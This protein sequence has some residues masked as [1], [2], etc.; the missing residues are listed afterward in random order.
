MAIGVGDDGGQSRWVGVISRPDVL[1]AISAREGGIHELWGSLSDAAS[2]SDAGDA[3]EL[4]ETLAQVAS[5]HLRPDDWNMPYGPALSLDG[6]RTAI[7]AD[8]STGGLE[9]LRAVAPA[10]PDPLFRSRVLDVVALLSTHRDR[11]ELE[12]A[13]VDALLEVPIRPE[14]WNSDSDAWDRALLVARRYRRPARARLARLEQTLRRCIRTSEVGY[15]PLHVADL[16]RKHRL[17]RDRAT[18]IAARLKRLATRAGDDTERERA[19]LEGAAAWFAWGNDR[20]SSYRETLAVVHSLIAEGERIAAQGG[21]RTAMRAAHLFEHALQKVRSLPRATR[22]ELGAS[23]LTSQLARRIRELGAASL[24][25]MHSFDS[26]PI[27]LSSAARDAIDR[28]KG[29]SVDE[30]LI[31]FAALAEFASFSREFVQAEERL[32]AHP[33]QSLLSYVHYSA[34]GRVIY[35]SSGRGGTPIYGVDPAVWRQIIESYSLRVRLLT[36]GALWPA[37]VQISNEHRLNLADFGR[38]VSMSGIVPDDRIGQFARGLYY[39]WNADFSTGMQLLVPQIEHLVRFHLAD[40]GELTST[41]T[42]EQTEMEIGI[43]GLME[44]AAADEVFGVDLAFELRALFCG[45]LGPN[46]RNEVAHGLLDDA[47]STSADA[48]YCWWFALRLVFIPYWN[49]AHD[50]VASEARRPEGASE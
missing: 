2:A 34:D 29:R 44:R 38:M 24:G 15:I 32:R 17:A 18:L 21:D 35:R 7:P 28:V 39:G 19:Y 31:R 14:V 43:S 13:S 3:T 10:I 50:V 11:M 8:F 36:A 45:P 1:S 5:L 41:L 30:A 4:L 37:F 20:Q 47:S 48:L 12:L 27:D 46:L 25:S 23:A 40:A 42:Q 9:M 6:R 22:D 16:L 26:G 33:L 49:G